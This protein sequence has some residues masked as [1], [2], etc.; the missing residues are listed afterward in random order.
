MTTE[1]QAG[2]PPP[3]A[4]SRSSWWSSPIRA[5]AFLWVVLTGLLLV[6]ALTVPARLMGAPASGQM[7]DIESTVTAFS[8]ASAP[9]AGLVWAVA[10]YSLIGWRYRG[11]EPPGEL[12]PP[13][14]GHAGTEIVWTVVSSVLCVFL[15]IWGLIILNAAP[16]AAEAFQ[17]PTRIDV[18]GQQWTWT[19]SYPSSG[20][21]QTTDLY[22]PV[23]TPILFNVTSKDVVHSF[24]IVEMGA[25]ID[26][27]PGEI[28]QVRVTPNKIGTFTVRC[29]ELCGLYH[30][31][32]QTQVHVLSKGDYA[33]WA[34][35]QQQPAA[36]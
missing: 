15:L 30:A 26:A 7:K 12:A 36:G 3:A 29:A 23:D 33:A 19:F 24:W 25:K 10:L 11:S 16:P 20:N 4:P 35:S 6:F 21:V 9:V 34:L 14:R 22:L 5:M 17:A 32:M 8:V 27:N 18:T 28:T 1:Q 13:L 2:S 31:Y